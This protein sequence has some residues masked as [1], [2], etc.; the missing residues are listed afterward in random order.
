[1]LDGGSTAAH[2]AV[3]KLLTLWHADP[4]L[5]GLREPRA[6]DQLPAEEQKECLALWKE[7]TS[8][9]DRTVRAR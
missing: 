9:L 6:L 5:A 1:M 2:V 8:V 7:V 4:D 3:G